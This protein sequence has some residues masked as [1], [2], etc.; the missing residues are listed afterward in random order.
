MD[1]QSRIDTPEI[2]LHK[3]DFDKCIKAIEWRKDIIV[4]KWCWSS[5]PSIYKKKRA[6][7]CY[8]SYKSE[9]LDLQLKCKM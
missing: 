6:L 3:Y 4:N 8:T 1:Q 9:Q 5:H 2:D 7:N